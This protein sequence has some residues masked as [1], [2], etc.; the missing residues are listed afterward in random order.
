MTLT[1][2][3]MILIFLIVKP[4]TVAGAES[5]REKYRSF[6]SRLDA[7]IAAFYRTNWDEARSIFSDL[8]KND[9]DDPRPY[10]FEAMVP[11]WKYFFADEETGAA[12]DFL[13]K[14]EKA[15][16][17]GKKRMKEAPDDTTTVLMMGGLY[18]YR[19]LV[20]ASERHYRTAVQS[21][22]SGFSYTRR[23]MSMSADN[24]DVL[25]GQGV[26]HYMMGTIPR[27]AR[28]LTSM[29]G[30][31]GSRSEGLRMLEDAATSDTHTSTD[32]RMILAY[33][34]HEEERYEEA[35]RIVEPLVETWPENIIFRYFYALSL[36]KAGMEERAAQH[37]RMV[38]E[39]NHPELQSIRENGEQRLESFASSPESSQPPESSRT[40]ESSQPPEK[41][42]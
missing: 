42:E 24:P 28:W 10:F 26:F 6:E 34:Y 21:G 17:V 31:S 22:A 39:R 32:A 3:I 14:S 33:L 18:G 37:Y 29:V 8:Q 7:G 36:D 20:A 38:V 16:N 35:L 19:G 30:L 15:I 4:M 25:I 12:R 5:D 13:N 11:F 1:S 2:I 40:S 41:T 23:L 9:R 27:E